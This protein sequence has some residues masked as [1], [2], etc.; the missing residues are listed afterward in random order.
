MNRQRDHMM[1]M[2]MHIRH[3]MNSSRNH[4]KFG[5]KAK[6]ALNKK[7]WHD[8]HHSHLHVYNVYYINSCDLF[9]KRRR[10]NT[11]Q[12][13]SFQAPLNPFPK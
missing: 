5:F 1:N 9:E 13:S 4:V 10:Y 11:T 8:R 3:G 2:H 12:E 7:Q 6:L